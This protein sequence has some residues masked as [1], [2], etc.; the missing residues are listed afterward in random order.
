MLC[1]LCPEPAV[2]AKPSAKEKVRRNPRRWS[3]TRPRPAPF[4][5]WT[6]VHRRVEQERLGG[7]R[8]KRERRKAGSGW[9]RLASCR[10]HDEFKRV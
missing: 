3:Q 6:P 2:L 5:A 1:G 8:K 10:P 9:D 7:L 4:V